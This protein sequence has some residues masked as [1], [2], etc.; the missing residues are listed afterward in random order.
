MSESK[1]LA[2]KKRLSKLKT[3]LKQKD[4]TD[5]GWPESERNGRLT[6]FGSFD[7]FSM[8][9]TQPFAKQLEL[10]VAE[11]DYNHRNILQPVQWR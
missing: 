11:A 1:P 8:S 3:N 4:F 6:C 9:V 5:N 7:V 10:D 2:Q